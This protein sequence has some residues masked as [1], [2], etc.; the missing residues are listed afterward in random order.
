MPIEIHGGGPTFIFWANLKP[1]SLQERLPGPGQPGVQ[2]TVTV[3]GAAAG[4]CDTV[5]RFGSGKLSP[6]R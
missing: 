1:F 2:H 4:W 5:S 3:P 6:G